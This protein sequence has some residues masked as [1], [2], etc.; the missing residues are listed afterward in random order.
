MTD[1]VGKL[2]AQLAELE[3]KLAQAEQVGQ[4][5]QAALK[6]RSEGWLVKAPNPVFD[7]VVYGVVFKDGCAFVRPG[8]VVP[9]F[10]FEPMKQT[11]LEKYPAEEQAAIREREKVPSAERFVKTVQADFGYTVEWVEGEALGL[12]LGKRHEERVALEAA[13]EARKKA[14]QFL[15]G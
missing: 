1:E 9:Y 15:V 5:A 6:E 11:A 12:H 3:K 7:G 2:K 14:E 10:V 13:V 4:A 8:Q